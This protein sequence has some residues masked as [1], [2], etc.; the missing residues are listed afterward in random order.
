MS[1]L[2]HPIAIARG[3]GSG[4]DGVHHFWVQR[5]TAVALGLLSP[6]FVWMAV[7]LVGADYGTVRLTL[8]QPFTA[9]LLIAFVIALFWHAKL[10]LQVVIE[11]YVHVRWLEVTLQIAVAFSTFLAALASILAIGRIAFTA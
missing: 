10:G 6:W 3:L 4:K 11:D 8:A 7:R 5:V 9:T 1:A 2:R